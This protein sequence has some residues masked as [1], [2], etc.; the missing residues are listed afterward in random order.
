M[1]LNSFQ[2]GRRLRPLRLRQQRHP[3]RL[4]R[5][6]RDDAGARVHPEREQRG[7]PVRG[8]RRPVPD[9]FVG[10]RRPQR[11]G[12]PSSPWP[13]AP[14]RT[15]CATRRTGLLA[16]R[17]RRRRPADRG[18]TAELHRQGPPRLG[19]RHAQPREHPGARM[20]R[21]PSRGGRPARPPRALRIRPRAVVLACSGALTLGVV[22]I[23]AGQGGG[24]AG[25]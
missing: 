3:G 20:R 9:G 15:R 12:D 23:A 5:C 24:G 13:A 17:D 10:A 1:R 8:P 18:R 25:Q 11:Q 6:R 4:L 7:Q 14:L 2:S 19:F 21:I 16:A 22:G